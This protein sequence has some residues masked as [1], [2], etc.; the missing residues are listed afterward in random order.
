[1]ALPDLFPPAGTPCFLL[2]GHGVEVE[3]I[4]DDI[5]LMQGHG[6]SRQ[7]YTANCQFADVSLDMSEAQANAY[8]D[9]AENALQ[10]LTTQFTAEIAPRGEDSRYWAAS[11]VSPPRWTPRAKRDAEGHNVKRWAL[12]GRLRLTGEGS[13]V[14]PLGGVLVTR[15]TIELKGTAKL[16]APFP[17]E[18][19]YTIELR[20]MLALQTRYTVDLDIDVPSYYEREDSGMIEREG[21]GF[22]QRE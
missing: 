3:P 17:L 11:W 5:D 14:K 7:V 9:W 18:T 16:Q 6:Y 19:R 22:L 1:M 15:Y 12:A 8:D 13:D 21:G 20:S 4:H 10:V 2:E